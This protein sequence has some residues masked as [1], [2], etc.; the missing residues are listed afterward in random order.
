M[1]LYL[2]GSRYVGTQADARAEAKAQGIRFDPERHGEK[3]PTDKAGLIAYLNEAIGKADAVAYGDGAE[4]MSRAIREQAPPEDRPFSAASVL[5]AMDEP[6]APQTRAERLTVLE[7]AI[8]NADGFELSS[9]LGNVISRLE[10]LR[11]E[12]RLPAKGEVER[13]CPECG[14]KGAFP[15][16]GEDCGACRGV[17]IA[18][19]K[20]G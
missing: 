10:E 19:A 1:D 15:E 16:T 3:V 7:E 13:P 20:G 12:A 6:V 14:G 18:Q 5:K 8:Q 4:A 11:R 2:I 17:E 9:L